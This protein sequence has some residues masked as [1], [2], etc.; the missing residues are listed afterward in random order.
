MAPTGSNFIAPEIEEW[1]RALTVQNAGQYRA[2]MNIDTLRYGQ[3]PAAI[4]TEALKKGTPRRAALA[5]FVASC[6]LLIVFALLMFLFGG[7]QTTNENKVS[8]LPNGNVA[9][10]NS[11]E[12]LVT[13][14][15]AAHREPKTRRH[16]QRARGRSMRKFA[17][18]ATSIVLPRGRP[19]SLPQQNSLRT[20][21]PD[22]STS[23]QTAPH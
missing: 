21:T 7:G 12:A 14:V 3:I 6:L 18:K 2:N 15:A 4:F 23:P 20:R 19:L 16:R 5:Y 1:S 9:A 8:P 22:I 13:V 10:A 17:V 11:E